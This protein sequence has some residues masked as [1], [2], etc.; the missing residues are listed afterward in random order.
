[1]RK[2]GRRK[3]KLIIWSLC[4]TC[5]LYGCGEVT[6]VDA[7]IVKVVDDNS[8]MGC[9]GTDKRTIIRTETGNISYICGDYGKEGDKIKGYWVEGHFDGYKNGFHLT[10]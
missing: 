7:V 6:K 2:R 4:L 5:S 9:I 1:M 10:R 8:N 3:M